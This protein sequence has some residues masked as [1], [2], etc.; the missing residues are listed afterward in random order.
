MTSKL[1]FSDIRNEELNN[2]SEIIW[3]KVSEL[4]FQN[5]MY[6]CSF[7]AMSEKYYHEAIVE[8]NPDFANKQLEQASPGPKT[9]E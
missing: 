6:K 2:L 1:S 8:A 9:V 5:E 4:Q 3:N 7:A